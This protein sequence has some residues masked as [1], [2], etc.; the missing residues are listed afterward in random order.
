VGSAAFHLEISRVYER[1]GD[2]KSALDHLSQ[3]ASAASGA[4]QFIQVHSALGRVKEAAGDQGGAIEELEQAFAKMNE[5]GAGAPGTA[6]AAPLGRPEANDLLLRLAHLH[7]QKGNRERTRTLCERGLSVTNEPWQREQLYRLLI[8]VQPAVD[9]TAAAS[10]MV[11]PGTNGH[12]LIAPSVEDGN[13]RWQ[14]PIQGRI[15]SASPRRSSKRMASISTNYGTVYKFERE[16]GKLL[17]NEEMR[18][19]SAPRVEE[20]G[21]GARRP[22]R[23][24]RR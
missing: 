16:G 8:E 13:T 21:E 14:A 17:W 4:A 2:Y 19:T 11:Y 23:G 9:S 12:R 6:T 24:A 3:A 5:S 15:I 7:A 10:F 18:A 20:K 22:R 1:Y